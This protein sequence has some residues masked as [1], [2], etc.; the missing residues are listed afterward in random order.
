MHFIITE[1]KLTSKEGINWREQRGVLGFGG[2][3][4]GKENTWKTHA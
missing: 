1:E 4:R 3:T 2:E